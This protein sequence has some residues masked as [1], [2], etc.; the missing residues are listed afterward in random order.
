MLDGERSRLFGISR[1]R[2]LTIDTV[3]SCV[4]RAGSNLL[5][6]PHLDMLM[7]D[8]EKGEERRL[9][10]GLA[11]WFSH[12]LDSRGG[13]GWNDNLCTRTP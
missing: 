10:K 11:G 1:V 8:N 7:Q 12:G 2:H 13:K 5:S 3:I 6:R 9:G 4:D